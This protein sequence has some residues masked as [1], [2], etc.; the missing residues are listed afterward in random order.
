MKIS[1][2]LA[3][4]D[5]KSFNYAIAEVAVK[6]LN[7]NGYEVRF[8]DLY[9]EKFPPIILSREIPRDVS[10]PQ[11]IRRRLPK[12][13]CSDND[14][15]FRRRRIFNNSVLSLLVTL[16]G[17]VFPVFSGQPCVFSPRSRHLTGC[18]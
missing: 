8:H 6:T 1:V 16:S 13:G 4:P 11:K 15:L 17:H 9:R 10:L 3:H 18:C 7:A 2:I 14:F 12:K 5:K